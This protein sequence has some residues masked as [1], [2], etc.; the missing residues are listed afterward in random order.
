MFEEYNLDMTEIELATVGDNS[1]SSLPVQPEEFRTPFGPMAKAAR[2]AWGV[3]KKFDELDKRKG[4]V[5]ADFRYAEGS[6]EEILAGS[7]R[8]IVEEK[9]ALGGDEGRKRAEEEHRSKVN[10]II[11]EVN[12]IRAGQKIEREEVT[13]LTAHLYS[14][15]QVSPMTALVVSYHEVQSPPLMHVGLGLL[16]MYRDIEIP[17]DI[18][19]AL[20]RAATRSLVTQTQREIMLG[21]F[22]LMPENCRH[23]TISRRPSDF[24]NAEKF[25]D[26][27]KVVS[28]L[29]VSYEQGEMLTPS[30]S[31]YASYNPKQDEYIQAAVRIILMKELYQEMTTQFNSEAE[32]RRVLEKNISKTISLTARRIG[33]T[34]ENGFERIGQAIE[35]MPDIEAALLRSRLSISMD[36]KLGFP[37]SDLAHEKRF[38]EMLNWSVYAHRF[39]PDRIPERPGRRMSRAER[40]ER[41]NAIPRNQAAAVDLIFAKLGQR[42]EAGDIDSGVIYGFLD[43][44]PYGE[45][46]IVS[47]SRAGNETSRATLFDGLNEA[48]YF[49]NITKTLRANADETDEFSVEELIDT[50]TE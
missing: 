17:A 41:K 20:E 49:P 50:E 16:P 44:L 15:P 19:R 8:D 9:K 35:G 30:M 48:S 7:L 36:I 2:G 11:A 34:E 46:L 37:R 10:E 14:R 31:E 33:P 25:V 47:L 13:P 28:D 26:G 6:L 39:G 42:M 22:R 24:K 40:E 27:V 1:E 23:Q 12:R 45:E 21:I 43:N 18:N 4:D 38:A 32:Y 3:L 29:L 5:M